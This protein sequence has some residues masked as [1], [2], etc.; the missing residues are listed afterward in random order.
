MI[1]GASYNQQDKIDVYLARNK[2]LFPKITTV[3]ENRQE[4]S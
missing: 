1:T 4:M 3:V 2:P